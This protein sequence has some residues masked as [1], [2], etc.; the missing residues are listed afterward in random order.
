[1]LQVNGYVVKYKIDRIGLPPLGMVELMVIVSIFSTGRV[2]LV[3][4]LF[5]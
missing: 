1:M 4:D 2:Y 5:T 3:N